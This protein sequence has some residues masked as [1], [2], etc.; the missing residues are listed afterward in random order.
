MNPFIQ[1]LQDRLQL[2]DKIEADTQGL[3]GIMTAQ[4][5]VEHLGG[6][7]YG[8]AKGMTMPM[9]VP[10][11][12]AQKMK[13][14]FFGAHYPFPQNVSMPGTQDKPKQNPPLRYASIGEAKAKL[15]GAVQTFIQQAEAHPDQTSVHGYF[16]DLTMEEWLRF[17]VKHIEHHLMQFGALPPADQKIPKLEKLLYK[18][19]TKLSADSPAKWG[20]MNAHQMVE[21]LS[22][23]FL[24]STGKF[25][26]P[27]QGTEDDA[28]RYW[29]EFEQ[30]ENP[31]KT[32]FPAV[33]FGEPRP[34]RAATI[35]E[36]KA[37]LRKAFQKYIAYC[38]GDPNGVNTHHFLGHLNINQWRQ[39]HIKHV[40][41]HLR[42]FGVIE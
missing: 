29:A 12:K 28:A 23:V 5:M 36:S 41:H 21:H 20:K 39:V 38:E 27:Y 11:E 3:W 40:E 35:E 17:H 10:P 18:L 32:V 15:Q 24:V 42:Q 16:G 1:K 8:T 7:I 14:R 26:L 19:N 6:V 31:W 9:Y 34:P 33:S 4:H 13:A 30:A 25:N 37:N 22:L 2:L